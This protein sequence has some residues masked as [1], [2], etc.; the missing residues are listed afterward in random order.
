[1]LLRF[2]PVFFPAFPC[3]PVV[4]ARSPPY[5]LSS[6]A[7]VASAS[8]QHLGFHEP[9]VTSHDHTSSGGRT[10]VLNTTTPTTLH[11]LPNLATL[12][13]YAGKVE[14][15]VACCSR[16][17]CCRFFALSLSRFASPQPIQRRQTLGRH[18]RC[19]LPLS[20]SRGPHHLRLLCHSRSPLAKIP[21]SC[22]SSQLLEYLFHEP[23]RF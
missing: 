2:G 7:L 10:G 20:V 23:R 8:S 4:P 5:P 22:R 6:F 16:R 15:V 9:P 13:L 17:A 12:P 3:L 1:M 21:I 19:Q 18:P 11:L 14:E